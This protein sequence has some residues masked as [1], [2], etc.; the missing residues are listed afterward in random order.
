VM[1]THGW[2]KYKWSTDT[3]KAPVDTRSAHS[4][5]SI[6]GKIKNPPPGL[7]ESYVTVI[8]Q[9]SDTNTVMLPINVNKEGYFF[10]DGLIYYGDAKMYFKFV[11]KS[12]ASNSTKFGVDNGLIKRFVYP[13]FKPS[14]DTS[15]VVVAPA[16]SSRVEDYLAQLKG[17]RALK[18]VVV[19]AAKITE[20]RK[21]ENTYTSGVFKDGIST[22]IKVG[23]DPRFLNY[24]SFFQYLQGKV[25]GV[26]ITYP[27]TVPQVMWRNEPVYFFLNG[28]QV[29]VEDIAGTAMNDFDY[30]KIYDPS[31]GGTFRAPG[32]VISVYTKKGKGFVFDSKNNKM[33]MM[34][35]YTIVKE[36]FSPDYAS[37][38]TL[39]K[40][41]LRTTLYWNPNI[42]LDKS[43]SQQII[44][45]YNNDVS[46]K[47]KFVLEG[48]NFDGK[49]VHMEKTL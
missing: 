10:R 11:N 37:G 27:L 31:M 25:P 34:P 29:G 18:E 30:V 22:T 39:S 44:K 32:A 13:F 1:L 20:N 16:L 19:R 9:T 17:T 49:L 45:F 21:L 3:T 12:L 38:I 48:M 23:D 24:A 26:I 36:F 7:P 2:R 14:P 35:G 6:K 42:I 41:D 43:N 5:L 15:S 40:P 46:R 47:F 8:V 4:F 33:L 28:F